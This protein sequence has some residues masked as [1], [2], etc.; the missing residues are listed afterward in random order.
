L[1]YGLKIADL[2]LEEALK[3]NPDLK[4][5]LNVYRGKCTYSD[6]ARAHGLAYAPADTVL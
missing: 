1:G 3:R 6:V 2:G 5:G 4:S